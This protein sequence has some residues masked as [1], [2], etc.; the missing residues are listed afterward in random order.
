MQEVPLVVSFY[1]KDTPYEE[2]VQHLIHSCR[3]WEIE[4]EVEGVPSAGSWEMNCAFKPIF[5]LKKLQE[6]NRPL[7]WVDADAIFMKKPTY[8]EEFQE[9]LAVRM[10]DCPDD[11]PSRIVSATIFINATEMAKRVVQLWAEECLSLL[12]QKGRTREMWDQEALRRVL[13]MKNPGASY[14]P[15]PI[16]YSKI[17]D[18][19]ADEA[20]CIDPVIIQNQASRRYK[21]WVN[22]PEERIP[23]W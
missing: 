16:A 18:H 19:P 21:R 17:Y 10:Y 9:D 3:K 14:K 5:I 22:C 2:E 8:L 12:Q 7:L 20:A 1:T 13:F 6:K 15:L 23:G 11:H 4:H